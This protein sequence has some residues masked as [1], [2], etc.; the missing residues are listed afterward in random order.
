MNNWNFGTIKQIRKN[1][2]ISLNE[3]TTSKLD[4]LL[5]NHKNTGKVFYL[6]K[7]EKKLKYLA[8]NWIFKKNFGFEVAGIYF[9]QFYI[10]IGRKYLP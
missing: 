4:F 2:R 9:R 1:Y 3:P 10:A 5:F 7:C 8:W 6:F